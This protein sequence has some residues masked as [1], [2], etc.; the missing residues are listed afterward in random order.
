MVINLLKEKNAKFYAS[1]IFILIELFL[2]IIIHTASGTINH[3]CSFS[4]ILIAF[5]FALIFAKKN[6]VGIITITALL[7]TSISDLMLCGLFDITKLQTLSVVVFL[8]AQICYFTRILIT[9]KN[10]TITITHI[11]VRTS[12]TVLAIIVTLLVLKENSNA[13]AILSVVY[14]INLIVNVIFSGINVK[15]EPLFFIGLILFALCDFFVGIEFLGGFIDI[16]NAKF[17]NFLIEIPFN[18]AWLFYLPSQTVLSLQIANKKH[19]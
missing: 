8:I 14:Y 11:A 13:L 6:S 17:I 18:M 7:F 5:I 3:V 16:T 19:A 9:Q 1:I 15:N 4:S 12:L 10:K 2:F